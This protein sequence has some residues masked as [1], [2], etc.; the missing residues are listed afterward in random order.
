MGIRTTWIAFEDLRPGHRLVDRL[1]TLGPAT[2]TTA[3]VVLGR[4]DDEE[5]GAAIEVVVDGGEV[6]SIVDYLHAARLVEGP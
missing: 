6:A 5:G 4:D 1:D 3:P 2:V